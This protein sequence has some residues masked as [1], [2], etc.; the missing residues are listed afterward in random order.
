MASP[1]SRRRA[2]SSPAAALAVLLALVP[3]ACGAETEDVCRADP[4]KCPHDATAPGYETSISPDAAKPTDAAKPVSPD[5]ATGPYQHEDVSVQTVYGWVTSG[6][7]MTLID[8][9]E[10]GE[11]ATGYIAGAINLPLG[12]LGQSLGQVPTDRPVVV[13]CQ[14]GNRSDGAAALLVTKGYKPVYDMLG[15]ISAWKAAGYPVK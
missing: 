12:S 13:Y 7:T 14:S 3:L 6:K 10:A 11:Y 15:G 2:R 9:R 8:V 1:R 5:A 4:S